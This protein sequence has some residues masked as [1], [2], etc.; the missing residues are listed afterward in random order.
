VLPQ[1]FNREGGN[2]NVGGREHNAEGI[3]LK[4][5]I[6]FVNASELLRVTC[7][8]GINLGTIFLAESTRTFNCIESEINTCK[9]LTIILTL[10]YRI[11][12]SNIECTNYK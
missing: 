1:Q 10:S 2:I 5:L 6:L 8:G 7:R 12:T 3:S 11:D 9:R 4:G